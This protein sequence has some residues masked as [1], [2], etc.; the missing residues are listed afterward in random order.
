MRPASALQRRDARRSS[1]RAQLAMRCPFCRHRGNRVVDSRMSGDGS[2]IRRRRMCYSCKRRFTTYERVEEAAP[3]VVKKDSRREPYDRHKVIAGIKRACEKRRSRW[4][5]SRRS[6]TVS[7]PPR[8]NLA[9]RKCRASLSERGDE[10]AARDRSGRLRPLRRRS[11]DRSKISMSS[12]TS[13][14]T[15]YGCARTA[16]WK[17]PVAREKKSDSL[18]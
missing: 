14:K 3:M 8:P 2:T 5:R 9:A 10:R 1:A 13:S 6:L 17:R 7:R 4:R 18:S 12:C 11:I 16:R 15:S